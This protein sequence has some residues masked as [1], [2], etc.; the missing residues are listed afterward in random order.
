ML[1]MLI[2]YS[3]LSDYKIK[4]I[5]KKFCLEL[6]ATQAAKD[7]G[8]N[9]HTIDSY[10]NLF[11]QKIVKHQDS[12]KIIL[13]GHIEIDESYFGSRH[14]GDPRG[15]STQVKIPVIGLLKRN[16]LVYTQIITDASRSSIM[17]IIAK[18]IEKSKSNIYT[19]K[20]RSYDGLIL[21]GYKHKR[22]NH[23]KE[24]ARHHNHINGIESFWSYVKRKMR[25]HNGIRKDKF[26]LY[27]KEAEFR[28]NNRNQDL[29]KI[30]TKIVFKS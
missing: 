26:Y 1:D 23:S 10:Y 29:Y 11:R 13:D 21:S 22:I 14:S 4:K 3:Q 28:F 18:L 17:P 27:L 9:R 30:L 25:K 2:K 19:D 8:L 15:R 24:F 20:W 7:I 12:Q 5:L 16:G 6:T